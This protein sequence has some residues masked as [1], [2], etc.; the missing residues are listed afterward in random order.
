MQQDEGERV[1]VRAMLNRLV[2][3]SLNRYENDSAIGGN[4]PSIKSDL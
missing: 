1:T 2:F 4:E 3:K